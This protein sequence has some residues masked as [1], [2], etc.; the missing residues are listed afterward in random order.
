AAPSSSRPAK[1]FRGNANTT[2]PKG[3]WISWDK[4]CAIAMQLGF[5]SF[6]K[7]WQTVKAID[8]SRQ[9]RS[10]VIQYCK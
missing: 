5:P 10:M 8:N 9:A 4:L 7:L 3:A 2:T 1:K 6:Q